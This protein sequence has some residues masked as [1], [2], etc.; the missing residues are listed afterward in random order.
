[1]KTRVCHINGKYD[2]ESGSP[3]CE[4][5]CRPTGE[6]FQYLFENGWLPIRDGEWYQSRSSRV[7]ISPISGNRR[8]KLKKINVSNTGDYKEILDRVEH[9]YPKIIRT[10]VDKALSVPH[11][12]YYFNDNIFSI[13]NWYDDIP[14]V[15]VLL[16]GRLD[17]SG[18]TPQVH[19]FFIDRLFGKSNYPYIYISEWY[20]QFN[21][22]SEL[23][24]FEWW[25]GDSWCKPDLHK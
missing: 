2:L 25:N 7:K 17:R 19:Y 9:L 24:N 6:S 22:K 18:V 15:P 16:G 11:E 1:M 5:F 21:Y 10:E 20:E 8:R 13:L 12:I 23:P 3:L 14:Y 4:V